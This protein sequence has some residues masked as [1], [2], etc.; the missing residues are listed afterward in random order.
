MSEHLEPLVAAY[1]AQR[2]RG[3]HQSTRGIPTPEDRAVWELDASEKIRAH[4][5]KV[6]AAV[7]RE[8]AEDWMH[9]D[10]VSRR[11]RNWLRDT[12]DLIES[13]ARP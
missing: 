13:E 11:F 10:P 6:K 2:R 4:D 1:V 9:S 5:Q 8:M 3:F 7:L 12:A